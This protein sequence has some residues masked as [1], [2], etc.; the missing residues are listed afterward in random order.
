MY[1]ISCYLRRGIVY[2]PT[3][4]KISKGHYSGDEPVAVVPVSN[5][6]GLRRALRE[7]I[8]RGNPPAPDLPRDQIPPPSIPKYASVKDWNTFARGTQ[9]WDIDERE[10]VTKISG[11]QKRSRGGWVPDP[12]QTVTMPPGSTVDDAINRMIA[13]LQAQSRGANMKSAE[14]SHSE[15]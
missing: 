2:I 11:Y 12:A 9:T 6:D 3:M 14:Q 7:T 15:N 10:G 4:G 1:F 13:V 5:T 8:A